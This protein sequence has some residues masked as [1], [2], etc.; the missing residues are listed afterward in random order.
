MLQLSNHFVSEM[1][2]FYSY[3]S[4]TPV[5][6][7]YWVAL[8]NRLA[9]ELNIDNSL[10]LSDELMQILAGNKIVEN[11][12]PISQIYSGHQFGGYTPQLGDGRAMC[13]GEV[14]TDNSRYDIQLKG[15]GLT[16][17]SRMGDG[18]AVL[19]STIREYLC[20]IAME[21]L[22]VPTTKALAIVGSDDPVYRETVETT[23]ILTRVQ[24]TNIRFG[25]FEFFHYQNRYAEVKQLA[26][27]VIRHHYPAL[28]IDSPEVY[29][30]WFKNVVTAT[31][32]LI[33]K[34]QALGFCHGV[35]NTDNMSII[36]DT[37]DYGPFGFLEEYNPAHICN[38]SDTTGR[39]SFEK[40]PSIGLWNLNALASVLTTLISKENLIRALELYEPTLKQ[41]Y[42]SL[43]MQ[44]LGIKNESHNDRQLVAGWLQLL[45][46]NNLD[47]T[48]SFRDLSSKTIDA[49]RLETVNKV[50]EIKFTNWKFSY[51][52]RMEQE[53][54][55]ESERIS[56]MTEINP[57]YIL[58]NYLAQR[59][60]EKA[61]QKNY[62][63][64]ETLGKI[65]E[66]PTA[67]WTEF[68]DYKNPA[69]DWAKCLQVSCSS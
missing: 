51:R 24:R 18:R 58:R 29:G 54:A 9:D 39:Y 67:E 45:Q 59:A 40:Q 47:Y 49:L 22:K 33:A 61:Q 15:A 26:N 52:V 12:I 17:Y 48:N 63:E 50:Q 62:S 16:P 41:H 14:K 11:S 25:H 13:L 46:K 44:K 64:I 69:P 31:A 42:Y 5:S 38:H 8:N 37:I 60:I 28:N 34:W 55:N 1:P 21:G 6:K 35:M 57:K 2:C 4:P 65:L 20:S 10:Q 7:P 53:Y 27:Y 43:M 68:D 19:R 30:I 66:N 3:V 36:G 32:E 56:V 23:A